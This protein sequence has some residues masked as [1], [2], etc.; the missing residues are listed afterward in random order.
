MA[1]SDDIN[2]SPSDPSCQ[3][4]GTADNPQELGE[5]QETSASKLRTLGAAFGL[6]VL[7]YWFS[8]LWVYPFNQIL[9]LPRFRGTASS[10]VLMSHIALVLGAVTIG[11]LYFTLSDKDFD[12]IDLDIP[13]RRQLWM[14]VGGTLTLLLTLYALGTLTDLFS[15]GASQ[16][17]MQQTIV[18]GG[19]DPR[20][21]L[22]MMPVSILVVGPAEEFIYRNLV[23]KR[24]YEAFSK[25]DSVLIASGIFAFVHIPA[26]STGTLRQ[27]FVSLLT[28]FCLSLV[29]G[30]IYAK[31]ENLAIPAA[32]HGSYNA[33]LFGRMYL[34]YV[35]VL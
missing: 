8:I 34:I 16:H 31:T 26:Y 22:L 15:Q 4:D 13:D 23:Q 6:G 12:Y 29:L 17:Q 30:A 20:F 5:G 25:R 7:G 14:I 27:M 33:A 18:H 3:S 28:V 9:K 24:L 32:I 11:V 21:L 19:I 1:D 35:G 2:Q 10:E